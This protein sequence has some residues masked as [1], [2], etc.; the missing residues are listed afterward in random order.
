MD[1]NQQD[2]LF[3]VNTIKIHI[4]QFFNGC[5][6]YESIMDAWR[7]WLNLCS[8]STLDEVH[9]IDRFMHLWEKRHRHECENCII[10]FKDGLLKHLYP[11]FKKK[12]SKS[13]T[14]ELLE[15]HGKYSSLC[16]DKGE[17]CREITLKKY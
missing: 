14:D 2:R 3:K 1:L 6:F 16:K 11:E 13:E 8:P 4:A 12:I 10:L 5:Y 7:H 9:P 17:S 15:L